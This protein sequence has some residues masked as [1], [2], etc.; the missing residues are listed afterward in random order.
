MRNIG[1]KCFCANVPK[2]L[3]FG[4]VARTVTINGFSYKYWVLDFH[5]TLLLRA[6]Q[7]PYDL[8]IYVVFLFE[9]SIEKIIGK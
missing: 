9:K 2:V 3:I 7:S 4:M 5:L 8:R 1:K 6:S